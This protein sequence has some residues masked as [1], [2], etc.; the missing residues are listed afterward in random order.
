VAGEIA[1]LPPRNLI[2]FIVSFLVASSSASA[3]PS[4]G[5]GAV[6]PISEDNCPQSAP[7]KGNQSSGIYHMPGDAYYDVTDPEE[8]FA[9]EAAAQAAGYRAAEV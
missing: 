7:I 1:G 2:G 4:A 5:G 8:C 3:S 9:S 6:P